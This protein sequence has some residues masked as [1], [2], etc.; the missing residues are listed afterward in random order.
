MHSGG[1][2]KRISSRNFAHL[3]ARPRPPNPPDCMCPAR[4]LL[5]DDFPLTGP[6]SRAQGGAGSGAFGPA[7][8]VEP[9]ER[10]RFE[11]EAEAHREA[12]RVVLARIEADNHCLLE[13]GPK[14]S[15]SA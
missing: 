10:L 11:D 8:V 14:V 1:S 15:V 13:P 4:V 5:R 7:R 3:N 9:V 12:G 6:P 2:R